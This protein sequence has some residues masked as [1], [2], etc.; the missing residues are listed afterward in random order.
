[1]VTDVRV[2]ADLTQLMLTVRPDVSCE[3]KRVRLDFQVEMK[4]SARGMFQP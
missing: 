3:Q 4:N 2:S 1:M